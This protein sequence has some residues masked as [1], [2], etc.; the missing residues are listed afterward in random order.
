MARFRISSNKE[1]QA[2]TPA[3]LFRDLRKQ[4]SI[5]FLW[6]HQEKLLDQYH[7]K[8]LDT[9]DLA[10]ELPTGS[11]KTLVGLL[12]GE[13]RRRVRGER[14]VFLCP[15][16]QLCAQVESQAQKYGVPVALLIGKQKNYDPAVFSKYQEAKA[17]AITTYSGVFNTNPKIDDPECILCDDAHAGDGFVGSLWSLKVSRKEHP[18]VYSALYASLKDAIPVGLHHAIDTYQGNPKDKSGV[19]LVSPIAAADYYEATKEAVAAVVGETNLSYPWGMIHDNLEACQIYVTSDAFEIRP[20]VPPTLT[21]QPFAGAKQRIYMSATLGENGDIERSFGVKNIARIPLPEGWEKRGTGRRLILFPNK[22]GAG[23][24]DVLHSVVGLTERCL[25]L[26]PNDWSRNNAQE[27]LP[28]GYSVMGA[29]E[30]ENDLKVFTQS[31]KTALLLANRYDGIDLPGTD[32]RMLVVIGVPTGIG[33]QERYLTERLNANAQ[34]QDRIRTRLTQA[35]GRCTRDESDFS[36]ALLMGDDLL[37]WCCT[38][39]NTKGLHPELQAEIKF[40]LDNSEDRSVEDITD[41]CQT[42][43][44]QTDD[45]QEAE[46]AIVSQ[47]NKLSKQPDPTTTVLAKVA[48]LEIDYVYRMWNGQYEDALALA[49]EITEALSGGDELKPYRSFWHHQAAAAAFLGHRASKK[50]AL[51]SSVISHLSKAI[52]TS[53]GIRWLAQL[54]A[55][56]SG[57]PEAKDEHLPVQ[58]RFLALNTCLEELSITGTK[59]QKRIVA[60]RTLI[61]S[62][63]WKKFEQGLEVLGNL[64]GATSTRFTGEGEPDGLW[65][66]GDWHA[67]VFEAKTDEDEKSG[68]SLRTVRQAKS[69]EQT[70]RS[71]TLLP[72]HTPCTTIIVSPRTALHRLAAPHAASLFYMSPGDVVRLFERAVA[73]FGNVRTTAGSSS[74]EVL[75][76][77]FNSVYEQQ[78]LSLP[79]LKRLLE[80]VKLASLPVVG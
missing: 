48:P 73:A 50:P 78:G 39:S 37:K 14:V 63:N 9:L 75:R 7:A 67:F 30:I 18:E 58:E 47:R 74:Q 60:A 11:G 25:V 72:P 36:V 68:V 44:N 65:V 43:L 17:I 5:K 40:G 45:W 29:Q 20:V 27:Y 1:E 21:H 70:A 16:R 6:G 62:S 41:L 66:F 22:S 46:Q 32:C 71:M 54:H 24:L 28:E 15:N 77:T 13:F 3:L 26:V 33:L 49:K 10:I 61:E 80:K 57:Q 52:G 2:E 8:H 51:K 12:I 55:K 53:A 38:S 69:H 19:E 79:D 59:Y 35:V 56:L 4:P 42:F 23:P 31:T 34:F 76:E 64:L